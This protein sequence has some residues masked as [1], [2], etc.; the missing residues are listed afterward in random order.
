MGVAVALILKLRDTLVQFHVTEVHVEKENNQ[1]KFVL[2]SLM[3]GEKIKKYEFEQVTS[4]L[5]INSGL[6]KYLLSPFILKIFLRPKDLYIITNRYGF[7]LANLSSLDKAI[8]SKESYNS[9][10]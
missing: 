4:Q 3:A 6:T 7:S 2:Q 8:N 10:H 1:L 9:T 5:I